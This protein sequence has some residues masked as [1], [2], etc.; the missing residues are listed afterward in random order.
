MISLSPDCNESMWRRKYP[1]HAPFSFPC[2]QLHSASDQSCL[3]LLH[4]KLLGLPSGTEDDQPSPEEH[5]HAVNGG[6]CQ[7]R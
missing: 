5:K 4:S 3:P 1:P 7:L 6:A 2:N